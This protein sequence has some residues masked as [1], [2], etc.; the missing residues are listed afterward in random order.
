MSNIRIRKV[1]ENLKNI[2]KNAVK[3][4]VPIN[5][6]VQYFGKYVKI[7]CSAGIFYVDKI[8]YLGMMVDILDVKVKVK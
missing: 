2:I 7:I 6:D 5:F 4:G 3:T 1:D 8:D